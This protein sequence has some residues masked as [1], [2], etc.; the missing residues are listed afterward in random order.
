MNKNKTLSAPEVAT[1]FTMPT[2][3][4]SLLEMIGLHDTYILDYDTTEGFDYISYG[5]HKGETIPLITTEAS[6]LCNDVMYTGTATCQK[7]EYDERQG[8]LEAIANAVC[9][10]HF[11]TAYRAAIKRKKF[12]DEVERTCSFCGKTLDAVAEREEHEKWHIERKKARHER[13]LLNRRAREIA[14]EQRAQEL[15]KAMMNSNG[16]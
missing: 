16:K 7:S 2:T 3:Q 4:Q 9:G 1:K 12:D 6:I 5:K 10:G 8:V 14:F 13:Y 11:D 15:A